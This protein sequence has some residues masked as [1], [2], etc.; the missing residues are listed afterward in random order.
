MTELMTW[1]HS[2]RTSSYHSQK[3]QETVIES[4]DKTQKTERDI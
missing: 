3:R 2:F 4:N 1:K